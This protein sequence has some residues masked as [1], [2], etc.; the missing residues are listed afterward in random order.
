MDNFYAGTGTQEEA[1]LGEED[2]ARRTSGVEG[3]CSNAE[4]ARLRPASLSLSL[5]SSSSR[6]SITHG[7]KMA[8]IHPRKS[9]QCMIRL[10]VLKIAKACVFPAISTDCRCTCPCVGSDEGEAGQGA[11]GQAMDDEQTHSDLHDNQKA[12]Y[13][14]RNLV[15]N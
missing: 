6:C 8:A 3:E 15:H 4:E 9:Y 10:Q 12:Q 11:K 7:I 1:R 2:L 14:D 13:R 5:L